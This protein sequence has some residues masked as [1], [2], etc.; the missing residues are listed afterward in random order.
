MFSWQTIWRR[1]VSNPDNPVNKVVNLVSREVRVVNLANAA[2]L[3][4]PA[5]NRADSLARRRAAKERMTM[6]AST[7]SAALPNS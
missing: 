2:K 7:R 5:S 1:T 4:N 3:V 6:R